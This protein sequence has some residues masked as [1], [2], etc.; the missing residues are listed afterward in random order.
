MKNLKFTFSTFLDKS[1]KQDDNLA[2]TPL[3]EDVAIGV[4]SD[5]DS[6]CSDGS[7]ASK[8]CTIILLSFVENA[9]K[10]IGISDTTNYYDI[11]SKAKRSADKFLQNLA[12]ALS[13]HD[14]VKIQRLFKRLKMT[15]NELNLSRR[16]IGEAMQEGKDLTFDATALAFVLVPF[17]FT[18]YCLYYL[19]AG[20]S[21]GLQVKN[22]DNPERINQIEF[23][24]VK[25]PTIEIREIYQASNNV[26]VVSNRSQKFDNPN[27]GSKIVEVGDI[28]LF[29]SDGVEFYHESNQFVYNGYT[30]QKYLMEYGTGA[31]FAERWHEHQRNAAGIYDDFALVSLHIKR[32]PSRPRKTV[33]S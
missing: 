1:K 5:G 20:D 7:I 22:S 8:V 15:D 19:G 12:A 4:V 25:Y 11:L 23:Q 31:G 9:L 3:R 10:K 27:L 17:G 30:F 13:A 26:S 24:G 2:V 28:L 33:K 6:R 16:R 21:Y 14:E 18:H 29:A 32:K